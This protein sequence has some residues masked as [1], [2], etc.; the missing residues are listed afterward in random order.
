[1]DRAGSGSSILR[2]PAARWCASSRIARP[3]T[4]AF[5]TVKPGPRTP[6]TWSSAGRPSATRGCRSHG[7][8]TSVVGRSSISS[9]TPSAATTSTGWLTPRPGSSTAVALQPRL[10]RLD[11][12]TGNVLSRSLGESADEIAAA[13][14]AGRPWPDSRGAGPAG[15]AQLMPASSLG[16][17]RLV[18][19][20]DGSLLYAIGMRSTA[21]T[22]RRGRCRHRPGSGSSRR[23]PLPSWPAAGRGDV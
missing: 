21:A 3:T 22:C 20:R 7:W 14:P 15:W 4:R 6:P 19:S 23:R 17:P 1:V 10:A 18:G 11:I 16:H 13:Q 2:T 12:R 8:R 5:A 9:G